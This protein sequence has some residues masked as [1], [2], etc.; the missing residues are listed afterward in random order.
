MRVY[1]Y[2]GPRELLELVS[3]TPPGIVVRSQ[4]ELAEW[5]RTHR[6][7]TLTFVVTRDGCMRVASRH[8]EHVACASGEPVLSAGEMEI[9]RAA[10]VTGVSNQSTGYCPEPDSWP[11]VANALDRAG[12]AHPDH[13]TAAIVFRLCE[14][15]HQRNIVKDDDFTCLVCGSRLPATW[16]FEIMTGRVYFFASTIT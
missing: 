15:C 16:N 11:A 8:N 6:E 14:Q 12:I 9:T 10:I 2:V 13:F 3:A 4:R 7:T 1:E 5:M